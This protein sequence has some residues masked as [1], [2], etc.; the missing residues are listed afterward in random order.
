MTDEAAVKHA[1]R[2][3]SLG[4][5]MGWFDFGICAYLAGTIGRVFFPSGSDIAQLLSSFAAFA[6]AFL[7]RPLGG[8]C[9]GAATFIAEYAPDKRRGRP[10]RPGRP[11]GGRTARRP[12]GTSVRIPRLA[13]RVD[14][15]ACQ[16][17]GTFGGSQPW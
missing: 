10:G 12:D 7:V 14:Q 16:S 2:A 13:A 8:E 3:A 6:V 17:A 1:V 4:N 15:M 11:R 9:G 5:A